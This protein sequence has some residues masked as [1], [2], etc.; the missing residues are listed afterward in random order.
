MRQ[1][2][3]YISDWIG[4]KSCNWCL[5]QN[6]NLNCSNSERIFI[7]HMECKV[8]QNAPNKNCDKINNIPKT[9]LTRSVSFW[10]I[11]KLVDVIVLLRKISFWIEKIRTKLEAKMLKFHPTRFVVVAFTKVLIL[12]LMALL[13]AI[14]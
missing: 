7:V 4:F 10:C 13:K 9:Y 12:L 2:A 5:L 14:N 6:Q 3:N 1:L 8:K 11:T